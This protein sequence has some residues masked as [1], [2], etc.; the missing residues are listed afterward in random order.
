M[1]KVDSKNPPVP[2]LIKGG[3]RYVMNKVGAYTSWE[4]GGWLDFYDGKQ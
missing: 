3:G 1:R 2:P 4:R